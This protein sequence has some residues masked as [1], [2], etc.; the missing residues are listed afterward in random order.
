MNSICLFVA[1]WSV[2]FTAVLLNHF[3]SSFSSTAGVHN[4]KHISYKMH[5]LH[6]GVSSSSSG[7]FAEHN[8]MSCPALV[9]ELVFVFFTRDCIVQAI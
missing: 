8:V 7:M 3:K 5:E 6:E 1:I 2:P 4:T 9:R